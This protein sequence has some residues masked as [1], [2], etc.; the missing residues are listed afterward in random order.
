[1]ASWGCK[2]RYYGIDTGQGTV[3]FAVVAAAFIAI[4]FALAAF[5]HALGSGLLVEHALT[6][7][8]HH[9]GSAMPGTI[10]DVFLY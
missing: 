7:A 9:A 6:S 4:S 1:M 5:W 2:R 8:S 10:A 3:E